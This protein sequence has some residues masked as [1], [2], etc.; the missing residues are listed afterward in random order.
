MTRTKIKESHS[1]KPFNVEGRTARAQSQSCLPQSAVTDHL[2]KHTLYVIMRFT[3]SK[4]AGVLKSFYQLA[5]K[6]LQDAHL[7]GLIQSNPVKRHR[8]RGAVK[9]P[10]Q[11][12]YTYTVSTCL[13][14]QG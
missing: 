1:L 13:K 12:S 7:F 14:M 6:D 10:R 8:P 4:K 11:A 9:N 3:E 2:L 5:N